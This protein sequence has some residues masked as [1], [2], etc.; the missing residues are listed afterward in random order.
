MAD[1]FVTG[2]VLVD[3][4]LV[5][6]QRGT[7]DLSQSFV[8][9]SLYESI[10]TPGMV[11]DID[12]L[13]TKDE[14]GTLRICGDETVYFK[15][16]TPGGKKVENVFSLY[17]LTDLES[18]GAQKSKKYT[19]Q[20][21]SEEVMYAKTNYVQKSYNTTCSDMVKDIHNNYMKSIKPLII[22]E[23]KG[24]H[25][26]LIPH[27][28]PYE[29]VNLIRSRS[30]SNEN[31]SSSYVF[32]E[33][34]VDEKPAFKFITIEKLFQQ[35]IIKRFQQSD[36][37][38]AVDALHQNADNNILSYRIPQ[39]LSSVERITLSGQQKITTFNFTTWQFETKIVE[40]VDSNYRDGGSN[41]NHPMTEFRSKYSGKIPPQ[42]FI[43]VD[44]SQRQVTY[45]PESTPD[46]QAFIA[47]LI[48]NSMRIRVPGDGI[49]TAG[50]L[51]HCNIPNKN[52]LTGPTTLD[53]LMTGKF[54]ISRIHHRI[55]MMQER[56]RY[57]SIIEVIKGK[58][59]EGI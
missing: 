29:A 56:P 41:R 53:P 50:A 42:S 14:L 33:T 28:N 5:F 18:V 36:A 24:S 6:S 16:H 13:D 22:E 20:C 34:R 35:D 52:G 7:L 59:E 2:D 45:L 26:I 19:L 12:V 43:P 51:I 37:I 17:R 54:L 4:L 11:C 15:F 8:S 44:I 49:L 38:N 40:T 1:N 48:Q 31:R 25:S 32:F 46:H 57:T 23:T 55:G 30:V 3:S 58:Y 47:L 39:Q 9:A 10:F 27:K 21:A